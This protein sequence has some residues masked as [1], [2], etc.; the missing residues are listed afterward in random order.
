MLISMSLC[1]MSEVKSM[2][3]SLV[4][5]LL[6]EESV[7]RERGKSLRKAAFWLAGAAMPV[8]VGEEKI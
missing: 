6:G 7:L 1:A 3:K 2:L 4:L 8:D 5:V